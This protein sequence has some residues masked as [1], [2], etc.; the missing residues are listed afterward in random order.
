MNI[1][2]NNVELYKVS[3]AKHLISKAYRLLR[4]TGDLN[5]KLEGDFNSIRTT[6]DSILKE[7]KPQEDIC[8]EVS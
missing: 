7:F 5:Y 6:C 4:E 2:R 3:R 8:N 1:Q